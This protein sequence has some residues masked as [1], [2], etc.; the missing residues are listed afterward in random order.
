MKIETTRSRRPSAAALAM[1]GFAAVFTL[2]FHSADAAA[3]SPEARYIAT[4]D[5]AIKKFSPMYDA[6]ALDDAATKAEAA[7]FTDLLT[8]MSAILKQPSPK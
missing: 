1:A 5:A 7:A 4:R 3:P 6:G 2:S 8:Q